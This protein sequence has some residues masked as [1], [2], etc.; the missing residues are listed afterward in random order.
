MDAFLEKNHLL[1]SVLLFGLA[2]VLYLLGLPRGT[3][4]PLLAAV[5]VEGIA[6]VVLLDGG[7][8]EGAGKERT[9]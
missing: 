5:L 8:R 1:V 9:R 7:S 2:A 6:W 3:V 4:A